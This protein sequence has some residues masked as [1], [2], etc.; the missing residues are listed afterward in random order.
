[1]NVRIRNF[2]ITLDLGSIG[3]IGNFGNLGN[4]FARIGT[5]DQNSA[6]RY[7]KNRNE[8]EAKLFG[9]ELVILNGSTIQIYKTM[10]ATGRISFPT[11]RLSQPDLDITAEYRGRIS[12][13]NSGPVN[14]SVFVNVTGNPQNPTLELSYSINGNMITGDP[15]QIQ[16]ESFNALTRGILKGYNDDSGVLGESSNF[17]K[18]MLSNFA[19]DKL[20]DI[21]MKTGIIQS[22]NFKLEDD[23]FNS[24]NISLSGML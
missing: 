24:A 2:A 21:L 17:S 11:A 22:A 4:I 20:T 19:S 5:Q 10:S 6:V 15:Q 23:S 16:V 1:M 3:N 13:T 9:G 18:M 12:S 7:V 8:A 14:Y